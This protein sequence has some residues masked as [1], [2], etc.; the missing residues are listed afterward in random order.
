VISPALLNIALHG[1]GKAAGVRY[2]ALG[3][4]AAIVARDSP[5][6]VTYADDLLALC[7]SREQAEQVK[8]RLAAWLA[9]RGLVFN[10]DKTRI[11]HLDQGCDFLG[12]NI[13]RFRGKLLTKPSTTALRR[14][15]ERLATEV[16]SL[17]GANAE[18]V[19]ARLNPIIKGWA[20]Y[21]RIGVSKRAFFA[22]DHHL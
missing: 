1:M 14:I 12:F 19:I 10:D 3:N 4:Q 22:L 18:A 7:H 2:H 17:H 15:R 6:L 13:R 21:Y 11:V 16:R 9:P 5:V 8:A 20:A